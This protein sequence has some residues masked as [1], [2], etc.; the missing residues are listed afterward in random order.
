MQRD[1][2]KDVFNKIKGWFNRNVLGKTSS[3]IKL[4]DAETETHWV[5]ETK[6]RTLFRDEKI[7]ELGKTKTVDTKI[8]L[9]GQ[10]GVSDFQLKFKGVY[11]WSKQTLSMNEGKIEEPIWVSD[12]VNKTTPILP[13]KKGGYGIHFTH[14][15]PK[16]EPYENF[17]IGNSLTNVSITVVPT[18]H[19]TYQVRKLVTSTPTWF[20]AIKERT[21]NDK[22][23]NYS[24]DD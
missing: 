21:E 6:A 17:Q 3:G 23:R 10:E 1:S 18:P 24:I 13:N 8:N 16:Q 20:N 7:S 5:L 22:E 9:S 4:I 19:V 15:Y 14:T 11:S 2:P 12:L